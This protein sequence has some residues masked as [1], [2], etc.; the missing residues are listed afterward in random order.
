MTSKGG[1]FDFK[2]PLPI[3]I[4]LQMVGG[5]RHVL[6]VD[7]AS[8]L[9]SIKLQLEALVGID[10]YEQLVYLADGDQLEHACLQQRP[11][12]RAELSELKIKLPSIRARRLLI[13]SQNLSKIWLTSA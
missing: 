12:F 8:T 13:H 9:L 1:C 4:Q 7:P 11:L 5:D 2:R 3:Q 10:V 6:S